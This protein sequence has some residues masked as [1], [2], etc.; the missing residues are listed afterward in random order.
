MEINFAL[1]RRFRDETKIPMVATQL[2]LQEYGDYEEAKQAVEKWKKEIGDR[3]E[4]KDW[5]RKVWMRLPEWKK[6]IVALKT[7]R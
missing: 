5:D 3:T 7:P 6:L 4:M 2:V 1:F